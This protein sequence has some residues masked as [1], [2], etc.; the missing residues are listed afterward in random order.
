LKDLVEAL[1]VYLERDPRVGLWMLKES[2]LKR[3]VVRDAHALCR[4]VTDFDQG[5]A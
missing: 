2:A 3:F 5:C 1:H 4:S